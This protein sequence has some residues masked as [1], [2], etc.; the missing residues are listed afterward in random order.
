MDY[1]GD[2]GLVGDTHLQCF[3]LNTLVVVVIKTYCYAFALDQCLLCCRLYG[4]NLSFF[5]GVV[6]FIFPFS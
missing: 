2:E 6:S 4:F 5:D 3:L 1:A